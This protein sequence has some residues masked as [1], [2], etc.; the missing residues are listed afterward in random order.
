MRNKAEYLVAYPFLILAA[1][2]ALFPFVWT[3][4]AATHTNTQIFQLEYTFVPTGNLRG[5][6]QDLMAASPYWRNLYNSVFI[7]VVYTALVLAIDSLA[8][9]AF[10]KLH[11]PGKELLFFVF[12]SSM[13]IPPQVTIVPLFIQLSTMKLMDTPWAVV[14]PGL[15]NVFGVFLMRQSFA[16]FPDE[17]I[18]AAR[19]DGAGPFK[20][21]GR[22]VLPTMK[23]AL[24][25]LGILSFVNQ[26]GNF[27][28]PLVA[29]N[30]K[31]QYTMPLVLSL[32]V[33]PGMVINYGAVLVGAVISLFPVMLMFLLFQKNF[34][35]GMLAGA[36]KG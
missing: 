13:F 15:A 24:T 12:L 21:F 23:P 36:V 2:V 14:L 18:E 19:I 20:T 27:L 9:Y 1:L 3:F 25:S 35:D 29:L 6:L 26:W 4:I 16:S 28:W 10:A 30:S 31:E 5:N 22:I 34:I 11:F 32:M 17:L 33:Q 8:G 7:A